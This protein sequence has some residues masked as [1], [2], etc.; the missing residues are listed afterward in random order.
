MP[1]APTTKDQSDQY[2]FNS[3]QSAQD[4]NLE[5]Q[6]L[7]AEQMQG[8]AELAQQSIGGALQKF[9]E[10]N[11][12]RGMAAGK[13]GAYAE[14]GLMDEATLKK[15]TSMKNRYELA[16]YL[17][18]MDQKMADQRRDDYHSQIYNRSRELHDYKVRNP[19]PTRPS[20]PSTQSQSTTQ[21]APQFQIAPGINIF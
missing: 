2:I 6:A 17:S 1:Y 7:Q 8:Y 18:V 4:R 10:Q 14:Q 3:M 15:L 21:P 19:I 11:Q 5:Q 9:D 12:I 20:R 13:L 16:G